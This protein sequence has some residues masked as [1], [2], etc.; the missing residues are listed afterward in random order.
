MKT[1]Q[2]RKQGGAAVMSIPPDFLKML[3]ANIG[4]VF[5]VEVNNGSLMAR[6]LVKNHRKRYSLQE[7][8]ANVTSEAIRELNIETQDAR[9]TLPVGRE[10]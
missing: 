8:L 7:L 4:D 10:Y 2:I 3:H 1:V 5:E 9:N 6:P